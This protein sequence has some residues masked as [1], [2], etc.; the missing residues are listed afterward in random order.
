MRR[1]ALAF[2]LG[3]LALVV[4][5]WLLAIA[6]GPVAQA[7]AETPPTV[8]PDEVYRVARELWCPLC[9]GVRLDSCELK[10][11][12]QMREEIATLLAQGKDEEAIKA[13][14]VERYGPQVLG[15]PPAEGF[16][17]LAWVLPVLFA[18][19]AGFY[20][21]RQLRRMVAA[22]GPAAVASST[23]GEKIPEDPEQDAYLRRLDEELKYYE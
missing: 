13:Y 7:Q 21:V 2:W 19:G 20:L 8:T 9:S 17:L 4:G 1:N 18:L 11:C 22:P 6:G 14:F 5:L 10:A 3:I 16:N 23:P 12:E 15:E